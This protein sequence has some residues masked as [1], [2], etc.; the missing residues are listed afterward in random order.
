VSFNSLI[1]SNDAALIATGLND[2]RAVLPGALMTSFTH[3]PMVGI[4]GTTNP[5][6]KASYY[7]YDDAGR[8]KDVKDRNGDIVKTYD[9]QMFNTTTGYAMYNWFATNVP[10]METF[11]FLC[12]HNTPPTYFPF[13]YIMDG[14][15]YSFRS[16]GDPDEMA[17]GA[18]QRAASSY[19]PEDLDC[20]ANPSKL[21][22][23]SRGI[24][25]AYLDLIQ[26]GTVVFSKPFPTRFVNPIDAYTP[27]D[28]YV[29]PGQY[30]MSLRLEN[31]GYAGLIRFSM[32]TGR[33]LTFLYTGDTINIVN[34][35]TYSFIIYIE[36]Q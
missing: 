10:I 34:G 6:G 4:S 23:Y 17:R 14:G 21:Q 20:T 12:Y 1:T 19:V 28:V 8:L 15:K 27:I 22:L 25:K 3:R 36:G 16:G 33:G 29:P 11:Y 7:D 9:Y 26:D 32:D 2:R 30:K 13:N 5:G 24:T 31:S 35:L 18:L